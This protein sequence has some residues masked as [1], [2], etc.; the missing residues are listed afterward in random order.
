MLLRPGR[1]DANYE[2][3]GNDYPIG[4]VRW[5]EQRNF[6]AMLDMI[7]DQR[8]DPSL[9]ISHRFPFDNAVDA[10]GLISSKQPSLGVL[11][12]YPKATATEQGRLRQQT[13]PIAGR[14]SATAKPAPAR[15]DRSQKSTENGSIAMIGAGNYA[16]QVLIPAFKKNHAQ[17]ACIASRND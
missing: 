7:A 14:Q 10:Y 3:Q 13:L 5:T 8:I 9:L 4:F 15:A 12:D 17:F 16:T 11:L 1:Y 2:Q 6:E